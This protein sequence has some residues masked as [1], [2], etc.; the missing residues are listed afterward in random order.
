MLALDPFWKYVRSGYG[1][2]GCLQHL[3]WPE[4]PI[5]SRRQWCHPSLKLEVFEQLKWGPSKP[6]WALLGL[7]PI[8]W[9]KGIARTSGIIFNT[10]PYIFPALRRPS[11]GLWK[12]FP[13]FAES[14]LS[15]AS[16]KLSDTYSS[17]GTWGNIPS[18][19]PCL[20]YTPALRQS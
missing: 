12:T 8:L 16:R 10:P 14:C 18:P 1:N 13:V 19:W 17:H 20:S 3:P 6:S 11:W 7:L 2:S 15:K 4:V 9:G 5:I